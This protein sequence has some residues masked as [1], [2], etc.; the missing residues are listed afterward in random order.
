MIRNARQIASATAL[1]V[2]GAVILAIAGAPDWAAVAF[3]ANLYCFGR[4][5]QFEQRR[6]GWS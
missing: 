3:A 6:R 5:F 1:A 4:L 2:L